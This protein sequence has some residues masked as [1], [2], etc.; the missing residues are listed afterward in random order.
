[1]EKTSTLLN[2]IYSESNEYVKLQAKSLKLEIYERITNVIESGISAAIIIV[3]ALFSFLFVNFG[4]AFWLS[5]IFQSTKTGFFVVGLFYFVVLGLYLLLKDKVAKNKV[6][7]IVLLKVS[8]THNDYDALLQEQD[9]VHAQV[10]KSEDAIVESFKE[11]KENIET[12]KDDIT[13]LKEQFITG[14]G[15]DN[16]EEKVGPKIPRVAITTAVDLLLQKVIFRKAGLVKKT[17]L[18][19]LT[20]ALLTSTVFKESKKTS[21]VE[22]I[23][24]KFSKFF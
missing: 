8:K 1:M 17:L 14:E 24:L 22:N 11:L 15:E 19:I 3:F 5:E 2:T 7:N 20:N 6:K 12:I 23:K 16:T 10:Q 18:P 21:L 13:R 9:I 4:L